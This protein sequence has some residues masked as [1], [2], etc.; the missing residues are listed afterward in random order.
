MALIQM[1]AWCGEEAPSPLEKYRQR[2]RAALADAARNPTAVPLQENG[3]FLAIGEL[4]SLTEGLLMGAPTDAGI[5]QLK[6]E[7]VP[8]VRK[9]IGLNLIARSGIPRSAGKQSRLPRPDGLAM[10][11]ARP[12]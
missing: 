4:F 7:F 2:R 11:N 9:R 1:G 6:I 8:S 3:S 12:A 10:T 5:L